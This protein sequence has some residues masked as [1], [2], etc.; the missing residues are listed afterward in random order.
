MI[1]EIWKAHPVYP[2]DVSSEGRVRSH[3]TGTVLR[4]YLSGGGSAGAANNG[5]WRPNTYR[6]VAAGRD[7]DVANP[8]V[9]RLVLETFVGP[10][11]GYEAD[12]VNGDRLDNRL[13]NLRWLTPEDN[14]LFARLRREA[15]TESGNL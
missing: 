15:S 9:H 11:D 6:R 10:G 8:A 7:Y 3:A 13:E 2:F 1:D 14:R 12:H 5:K 4:G